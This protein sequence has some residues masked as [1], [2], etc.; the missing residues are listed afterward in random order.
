MKLLV[1]SM[2]LLMAA[3]S[4]SAQ[5]SPSPSRWSV[6]AAGGTTLNGGGTV[7]SGSVGMAPVSRLELLVGVERIHLPFEREEFSDGYS[8]TRG[9]TLTFVSGEARLSLFPPGRVSPFLVAGAGGGISR[10]NVNAD[11]PDEIRNNLRVVY[12]GGGV[13]LPIGRAV[14]LTAEARGMLAV[15]DNDGVLGILPVRAGLSW[16]F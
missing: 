13:R 12:A 8:V 10:P 7:V 1:I 14:S 15:E 6:N 5:T 16:R 9:G 11:F 2:S 3:A 4:A